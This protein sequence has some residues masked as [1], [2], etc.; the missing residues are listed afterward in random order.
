LLRDDWVRCAGGERPAVPVLRQSDPR[1]LLGCGSLVAAYTVLLFAAVGL[2]ETGGQVIA[3]TV[4][5][6]LC[7]G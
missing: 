4:A 3:A 1:Y 6:Y 7:R 5:N 2:A